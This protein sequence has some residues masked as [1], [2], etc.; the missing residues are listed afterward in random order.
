ML[1][2]SLLV[3]LLV[4]ALLLGFLG[5]A[6]RPASS[7]QEVVP[8]ATDPLYLPL[9]MKNAGGPALGGCPMFPGDNLW[10]TDI[11]AYPVHPN[12]AAFIADI[13]A[14]GNKYL[15]ADFGS[16]SG[17]GIP[18]IVVPQSQTLVP[19]VFTEYGSESDPG[20]YPIPSNAPIE[21]GSDAHVLVLQ[22]GAC[23]LYELYHAQYVGPGWNAGSGAKWDLN[24]NL[25]RPE[26]WTSAD[27]AGL[28]ILPGLA[29]YDEAASGAIK[30]ALRFTVWRTQRGYIHP[31]THFAGS[32]PSA[33]PMGLRLRLKASYDISGYTGQARVILEALKRYGMIVADNGSSWFISGAPYTGPGQGWD[34]ADLNQLK[35]VPGAAFEAVYTGDIIPSP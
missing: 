18:Y 3:G 26:G 19:I 28:P 6:T 8:F 2:K 32:T 23:M 27:A 15:H 21:A 14:T 13:N 34:D 12:S 20:P 24:S 25:L 11:S 5:F 10:N 7:A 4:S 22:Q 29:R 33:P 16:Y 17:Y 1:R 30:H 31:A 35:Q 9:V